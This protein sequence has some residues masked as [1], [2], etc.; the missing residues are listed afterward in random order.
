M[1]QSAATTNGDGGDGLHVPPHCYV[2][3]FFPLFFPHRSRRPVGG[4]GAGHVFPPASPCYPVPYCVHGLGVQNNFF[5]FFFVLM[6]AAPRLTS[7]HISSSTSGIIT[8]A[9]TSSPSSTTQ[10]PLF[11]SCVIL[12]HCSPALVLFIRAAAVAVAMCRTCCS[13]YYRSPPLHS[14]SPIRTCYAHTYSRTTHDQPTL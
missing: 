5:F 9:R 1:Y 13:L 4:M 6:G 12:L 2:V 3:F 11:F 7:R 14:L 8:H 10:F